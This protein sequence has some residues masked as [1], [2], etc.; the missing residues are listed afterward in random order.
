MTIAHDLTKL[1]QSIWYDNIR[2]AL[3]DSGELATLINQGIRGVTSNPSIFEK[4]IAGSS[5]YDEQLQQLVVEGKSIQEIYETLV[6]D[7]IRRTADLL[8]SIYD[9]SDGRD[10]YISLEVS[11]TLARDTEGTIAEAQ[12]FFT[13]LNRPNVMIKVPATP[14]G[15][16]AIQRLISLGINVN[17]TLIFSL[18]HYEAVATAYIEG[19]QTF[20]NNGGDVSK[21]AS[22]ASFFVSRVDGA[23]DSA[24]REAGSPDLQGKVAIANSKVA[25]ARFKEFFSGDN[26]DELAHQGAQIQRV[27]WASTSV[28]NP[29]YPD[30]LYVDQ[31]IGTHTVNTVPPAT[32]KALMDHGTATTTLD[33]NLGEAQAQL[34]QLEALNIDL[35]AITQKLQDDGVKSFAQ[36]F[37]GL[38]ASIAEKRDRLLAGKKKMFANLGEYQPKVDSALTEMASNKIMTRIWQH[39]HTVWQDTPDEITNR[40]GWLH[41]AELMQENVSRL[42]SLTDAV[43]S[44]GYTH[45][46]LL[47]MGGSSLAPEVFYKTFGVAK[48]YLE[49]SVLDTTDADTVRQVDEQLDVAKTL[50]IVATKSGG[51]AETLSAFKY[52][53][54]RTVEKLGEDHAGQHFIAITDP[55]SQLIDIANKYQF[56]ETFLND[57]NIGGRYSA[58]SYFGLVPATLLGMDVHRLLDQALIDKSNCE[59]C[60]VVGQNSGAWLGAIMGE[61]ARAGRDKITFITSPDLA[62]FGDWVEQLIAEST[63]KSGKGIVPIVGEAPGKPSV[64]EQDRLFIYIHLDD[65]ETHK[66][67]IALLEAAGHPVVHIQLSNLYEIGG[68]FFLWEMA[69]VVAGA[70]IGIHPF[71]QPNVE[72]A[73]IIARQMITAYIESGELPEQIPALTDKGIAVYGE[74][75]QATHANEALKSFLNQTK[76]GDYVTLQAYISPSGDTDKALDILRLH[77]RDTLKVATTSG[78]GPRF[79]H[80]TG[81]LHKGDSGNGLFI[82]FTSDAISDVAIP[83]EAGKDQSSMTF[84]VLKLA[85]ALGDQQALLEN[86]RRVIRF[87]LGTDVIAGLNRLT[88]AFVE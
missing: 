33:K 48:G 56:R 1:G 18:Q 15:I 88:G 72:S 3:L 29:E 76:S 62:S 73:K 86:N 49:L 63:G 60:V 24:L 7:D 44:D 26:W 67:D 70:L 55:G 42:K 36:A 16:P 5:D 20:A 74:N 53:Y 38:M 69:T 45:A 21:V 9:E 84:G 12:R 87:H 41:I 25:Y 58:L 68:Q 2:R 43:R 27:L 47:G 57:P 35:K 85:Q 19:L 80:S 8:R 81:Q 82:Q 23:V 65:E 13:A 51:T 30:T 59:S 39:D 4:A 83:D 54:N 37:E 14:A 77:I 11:P 34:S 46:L 64:Y 10:G 78:Y 17:V 79:L 71:N 40:L 6:L 31:L 50:F 61:L 22:V 52:F 28:K 75:I 32:L 66:S